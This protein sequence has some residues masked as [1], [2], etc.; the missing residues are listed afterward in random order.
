VLHYTIEGASG[1]PNGIGSAT[2]KDLL[3]STF[4]FHIPVTAWEKSSD[5][6]PMRIGGI[7]S[8]GTLDRQQEQ[9]VQDGLNF[10]PFL[11]HGWFNDNHG[12]KTSDVLGYP[13]K[14]FRVRKGERLPNGQTSPHD[15][16]WAEGYLLNTEEGR[17]VYALARSLNKAPTGRGLGFSIEGKV[18]NRDKSNAAKITSA[19]VHHVAITHVPVNTDTSLAVLAKALMAGS[20]IEA[21]PVAPGEGFPLR[22]ESLDG[23]LF[24]TS[25]DD[26]D[27]EV[28]VL[29]IDPNG[30]LT[31]A[32]D[33]S[34]NSALTTLD[35]IE[36][37]NEALG[38]WTPTDEPAVLDTISKSDAAI[39]VAAHFPNWTEKQIDRLING[40]LDT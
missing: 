22:E 1:P 5:D 32:G 24:V 38:D 31:K 12:N 11:N 3:V 16:W 10:D 25:Y 30:G 4:R 13:T 8:T 27:E 36:Y 18:Q 40:G 15:G 23:K 9:V 20:S 6:N 37:L 7:V 14:A 29:D 33:L 19:D 21:P 26:D 28:D 17:K 34:D 39:L 35:Y 2:H